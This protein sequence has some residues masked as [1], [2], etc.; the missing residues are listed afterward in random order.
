MLYVVFQIENSYQQFKIK[1]KLR[2]IAY[3]NNNSV[4]I[5]QDKDDVS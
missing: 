1:T 4:S 3:K 5:I 2:K